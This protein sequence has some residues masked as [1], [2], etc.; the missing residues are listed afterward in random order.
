MSAFSI[1]PLTEGAVLPSLQ[2]KVVEPT[3]FSKTGSKAS[4][5]P[6]R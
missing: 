2:S 1:H 6:R 3:D 5:V 4:K